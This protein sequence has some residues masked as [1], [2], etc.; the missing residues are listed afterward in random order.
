MRVRKRS[1]PGGTGP[2]RGV[3]PQ[4][5][6]AWRAAQARAERRRRALRWT[7]VVVALAALGAGAV[8]AAGAGRHRASAGDARRPHHDSAAAAL[9]GP[10]GP[11]AIVLETGTALAPAATPAQGAP[12]DGIRCAASEQVA[13]HVHTHLAVYVDGRLRPLSPGIGIITPM[14]QQTTDGPFYG[15]SRCYYWLHVHAQDGIIHIESPTVRTYTLGQFFAI[16]HQPLTA[17]RVGPAL[18]PVTSFV[19]GRPYRGDPANI[20]LGSRED[21]Q[22]DVG[23][24]RVPPRRVDWNQ[25]Q[26]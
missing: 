4:R 14:V 12:V 16:W 8:A 23:T 18:G 3:G 20:E 9:A 15:A 2:K 10:P 1:R 21:V 19:D 13:Y 26:L 7:A 6:A 24:P 11:E 22:L 17:A 25:S 5:G